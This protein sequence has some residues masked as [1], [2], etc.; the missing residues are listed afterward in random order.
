[1]TT[2]HLSIAQP[3]PMSLSRGV[4]DSQSDRCWTRSP[5]SCL[6]LSIT[7]G[8]CS[9]A[10]ITCQ[11]SPNKSRRVS[12]AAAAAAAAYYSSSC[13]CLT[14]SYKSRR[15]TVTLKAPATRTS[16]STCLCVL[17]HLLRNAELMR[18]RDD[19]TG[20]VHGFLSM[21]ETLSLYHKLN[22]K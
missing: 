19:S 10:L 15:A 14:E 20:D 21:Y 4:I 11:Q 3:S 22:V 6:S 12:A 1:L 8:S 2:A 5:A 7:T 18:Q 17:V 9:C 13:D 16:L